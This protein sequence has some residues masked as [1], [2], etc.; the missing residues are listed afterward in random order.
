MK[1]YIYVHGMDCDQ[2]DCLDQCGGYWVKPSPEEAAQIMAAQDEEK[3]IP[4][5]DVPAKIIRRWLAEAG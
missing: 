3:P 5:W 1:G 2:D 4:G